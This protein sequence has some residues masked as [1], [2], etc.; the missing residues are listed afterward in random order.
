MHCKLIP[1]TLMRHK[2]ITDYVN[3]YLFSR[4]KKSYGIYYED[5]EEND[6][7]IHILDR[8]REYKRFD[9]LDREVF[10]KLIEKTNFDE[11]MRNFIIKQRNIWEE[12]L[13]QED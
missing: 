13:S 1:G 11:D 4:T 6:V 12:R 3:V 7:L 2:E 5:I 9:I 10:D 8:F